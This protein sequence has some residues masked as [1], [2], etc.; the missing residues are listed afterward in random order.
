MRRSYLIFLIFCRLFTPS[1]LH[2]SAPL[3]FA[4]THRWQQRHGSHL[5]T[6]SFGHSSGHWGL[7]PLQGGNAEHGA[8]HGTGGQSL[9]N[10]SNELFEHSACATATNVRAMAARK[11]RIWQRMVINGRNSEQGDFEHWG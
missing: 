10:A 7:I 3:I 1:Q 11:T 6:V 5:N 9:A 8:K 4:F 2:R